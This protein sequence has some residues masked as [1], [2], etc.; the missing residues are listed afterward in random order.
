MTEKKDQEQRKGN[1]KIVSLADLL[2]FFASG[3]EL[4]STNS[5]NI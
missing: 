2:H 4:S 3:L 5:Y 1:T